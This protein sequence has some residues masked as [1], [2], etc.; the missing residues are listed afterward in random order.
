LRFRLF[1]RYSI[2]I[3]PQSGYGPNI[4][5]FTITGREIKIA[6]S[7]VA[8]VAGVA[9]IAFL[10][11]SIY[12]QS[13]PNSEQLKRLETENSVL[14]TVMAQAQQK[15][16]LIDQKL[17]GIENMEVQIR[18]LTQVRDNARALS[19][20]PVSEESVLNSLGTEPSGPRF[21][22]ALILKMEETFGVSDPEAI[23][24]KLDELFREAQG[25]ELKLAELSAYVREQKFILTHTPS[26]WPVRGW[27]TSGFGSRPNPFTHSQQFH[28]GIDIDRELGAPVTVTG[29]G[30]VVFAG[31][32][33]GMGKMLV[34]D[35]GLGVQTIY[36]HLSD[37]SAAVGD[38]V[39]RGQRVG[40][41]GN[42]G[43]STGSHLH[44]E[45]RIH[46]IPRNPMQ[47]IFD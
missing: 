45:V 37:F 16:A 29:D 27:V 1:D 36:A 46:G 21:N 18:R 47:Y 12:I 10:A 20:G 3:M 32:Q 5:R 11:A 41:V 38:Q 34:V 9:V 17:N 14:R 15:M 8:G 25:G 33:E 2:V 6:L 39:N 28:Q 24:N 43:R 44:Y 31:V 22:E 19:M 30:V 40:S 7:V 42:T 4:H 23:L 26:T 13:M 35:H